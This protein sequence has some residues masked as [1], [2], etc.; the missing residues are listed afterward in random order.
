MKNI[1]GLIGSAKL[2]LQKVSPKATF[3][4]GVV[5]GVGALAMAVVQTLK[6]E[7][8]IDEAKDQI[9][10][11]KEQAEIKVIDNKQKSKALTKIYGK[12]GLKM[13]KL[14]SVPFALEVASVAMFLWSNHIYKSRAAAYAAAYAAVSE[15]FKMYRQR[16]VDDQGAEKDR[17]YYT[18][19]KIEIK[20]VFDPETGEKID[21]IEE[22]HNGRPVS[23]YARIFD[24]A[25][26]NWTKHAPTN[27]AMLRGVQDYCNNLLKIRGHLFLNEV[28]D[29]LGYVRTKAGAIVGWK[30]GGEGDHF[31]DFGIWD[32]DGNILPDVERDEPAIWMDFNVDGPIIDDVFD[33]P[34]FNYDGVI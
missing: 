16:V 32:A 23:Q 28:Y 14:Y 8:V 24:C 19:R 2:G 22:W 34:D 18:G 3:V 10:E 6:L 33:N 21:W 7:P 31:V 5:F 27:F 29:Q 30:N 15:A 13:A 17:E 9:D 11:V 4:G 20:D 12:V 25:N 1:K 26:P